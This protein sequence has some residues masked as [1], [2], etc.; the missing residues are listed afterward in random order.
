M[1]KQLV[2]ASVKKVMVDLF[3]SNVYLASTI[4]P[5]VCL[6]IARQLEVCKMCA[7]KLENALVS[8]ILLESNVQLVPQDII[9]IQNVWHA[10]VTLMEAEERVVTM[11]DNVLAIIISMVKLVVCVRKDSI[12]SQHVKNAIVILRV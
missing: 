3:A 9:S 8:A 12:I 7:I 1:T 10:I 5:L 4:S 6:A 2:N 11:R